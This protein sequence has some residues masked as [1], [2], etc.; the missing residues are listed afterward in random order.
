MGDYSAL[1]TITYLLLAL[2]IL[3]L[4]SLVYFARRIPRGYGFRF[5]GAG[6]V[7]I[8]LM[9]SILQL[10]PDDSPPLVQATSRTVLCS[11]TQVTRVALVQ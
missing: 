1:Q 3:D 4:I 10:L 7:R 9:V 8:T 11:T 6:L 5:L 2:I